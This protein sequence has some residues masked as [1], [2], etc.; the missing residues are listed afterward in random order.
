MN[1]SKKSPQQNENIENVDED[2]EEYD[3]K[4]EDEVDE[5]IDD[6]QDFAITSISNYTYIYIFIIYKNF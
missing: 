1:N 4:F 6:D 5:D 3:N 2:I